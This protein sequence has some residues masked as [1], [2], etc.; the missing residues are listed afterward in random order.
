RCP[1]WG[2]VHRTGAPGYRCPRSHGVYAEPHTGSRRFGAC[3]PVAV[4]ERV[5]PRLVRADQL[6]RPATLAAVRSRGRGAAPVRPLLGERGDGRG[7]LAGVD[8]PVLAA[9]VVELHSPRPHVG[10][11]RPA[12]A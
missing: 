6:R 5:M 12:R 7:Y 1:S 8:L 2:F 11:V 4:A 10:P 3:S 9:E